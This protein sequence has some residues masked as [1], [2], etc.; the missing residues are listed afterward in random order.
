MASPTAALDEALPRGDGQAAATQRRCTA[1]GLDGFGAGLDNRQ[2]SGQAVLGPFQ[3]HGASVVLLDGHR[4]FGQQPD[5][6]IRQDTSRALLAGRVDGPGESVLS[7]DRLLPLRSDPYVDHRIQCGVLQARLEDRVLIG[8]DLATDD[9]LAQAP[10][11]ADHDDLGEAAL[12][13]ESEDHSGAS[14]V[15]SDHDLDAYGESHREVVE[16]HPLPVVDHA[17]GEQ[18][19]KTAVTG[20]QQ[21]GR[22]AH[23]QVCLLLAGEARLRQVLRSGTASHGD[24]GILSTLVARELL[25]RGDELGPQPGRQRLG[26][27]HRPDRR[28]HLV[29]HGPVVQAHNL[30]RDP[31]TQSVAVEQFPVRVRRRRETRRHPHACGCQMCGHLSQ[32][33][34]LATDPADILPAELCER[35]DASSGCHDVLRLVCGGRGLQ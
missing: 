34:I 15:R 19:G 29:Q 20:L 16:A 11:R 3:V 7:I 31:R 35:Y 4:P 30:L 32:R 26:H 24:L 25:V 28:P 18:R 17:V 27:D 2:L 5:L 21:L 12:R 33:G 8:V 14:E 1:A 23:I 9:G 6:R 13:V 10:R 22:P